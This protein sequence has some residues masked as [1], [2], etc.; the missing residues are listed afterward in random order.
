MADYSKSG[1]IK[2][3]LATLRYLS[4]QSLCDGEE[5][6]IGTIATAL[7]DARPMRIAVETASGE[8]LPP[9]AVLHFWRLEEELHHEPTPSTESAPLAE[10]T[11]APT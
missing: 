4:L 11:D 7:L 5:W 3:P 8:V 1:N 9:A 2:I 6:R 10:A